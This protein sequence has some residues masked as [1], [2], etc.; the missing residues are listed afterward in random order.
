MMARI[1]SNLL[2]TFILLQKQPS[3]ALAQKN[4]SEKCE[5]SKGSLTIYG[6]DSDSIEIIT[7]SCLDIKSDTSLC[8]YKRF[9]DFCP[10]TCGK[11]GGG[12][13]NCVLD[14]TLKFPERKPDVNYFYSS[15]T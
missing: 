6:G 9:A 8:E 4:A 3:V 7:K 5:D 1:I 15:D 2:I 13:D 14:L 11:C 12:N 10:V